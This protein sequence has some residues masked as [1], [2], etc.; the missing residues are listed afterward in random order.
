V[1]FE[2]WGG[3]PG[4]QN[5]VRG[6]YHS[7]RIDAGQLF[8]GD[9]GRTIW[10]AFEADDGWHVEAGGSGAASVW[11]AARFSDSP[12]AEGANQAK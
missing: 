2:N 5:F 8:A 12:E 6:P 1:H 4:R 7:V 9:G 3:L 11:P 10:L